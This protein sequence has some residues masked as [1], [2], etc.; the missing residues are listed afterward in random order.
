MAA[1]V[2]RSRM[3]KTGSKK[4]TDVIRVE[5]LSPPRS[6]SL[7][8]SGIT[9]SLVKKWLLC[10][11]AFLLSVNKYES[12]AGK[13]SYAFGSL[14]H[15][16][17]DKLYKYAELHARKR[18]VGILSDLEE[19]IPIWIDDYILKNRKKDLRAKSHDE[20]ET[21]AAKAEALLIEY[22]YTFADD[23][24]LKKF[25]GIEEV[26]E[27]DFNGTI[28]RKKQD[29]KYYDKNGKLWLMEHKTKGKIVEESIM[30]ALKMDFQNLWYC[31]M[32]QLLTGER[33][34]GVLYN[35]IRTPGHKVHVNE[36]IKEYKERL[37]DLIREDPAHF[38]KRYP[39]TYTKKD[40]NEFGR[41]L[42]MI[43]SEIKSKLK[44]PRFLIRST[45]HCL[46]S[47]PCDFLKACSCGNMNDFKK[48]R[49]LFPE[50]V[51]E[52]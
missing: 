17:L 14:V 27:V 22:V 7:E 26:S 51:E 10:K 52:E 33:V 23:F 28:L 24:K 2:K 34:Y 38:F 37:R 4:K 46:M 44:Y 32:E 1:K 48:R 9:Q 35:V 8:V 40:L 3:K 43:L 5:D 49:E 31:Y 39:V 36:S 50:L 18:P 12:R 11:R 25:H 21:D 30:M 47:F 41:E 15:E 16:V 29:G 19:M 6:Y 13:K 42:Y 45:P 20:L